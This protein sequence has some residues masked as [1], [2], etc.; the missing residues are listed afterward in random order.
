MTVVND[1]TALLSG[2]YWNGIEV[3][4]K[5]VIVTYSYPTS[6]PPYDPSTPGFTAATDA[7]F[8][9]FT[10]TEQRL[11]C[12]GLFTATEQTEA[13]QALGEWSAA[14]GLIFL[15]VAP[16]KGDINFA[17]IDFNTTNAPS[18]AG[19]GGIGFYP[20]GN[21][22]FFSDPSYFDDL[23]VSGDVFMN[24]QFLSNGAVNY[25]TLLHEIGHAVGL[26]H[27]TEVV[28][29]YAANPAVTHDQVLS[30][31]DPNRTV[32][33]TVGDGTTGANTHLLALDKAAAAAIYGPAGA[34]G[35][36]T[37]SASGTDAVSSWSFDAA[38]QT[39]T[40]TAT[41]SGGTIHGS[42]VNDVI[43][44]S[45]G[46]DH[47][48]GLAGDDTLIGG[49][50]N[51][52]LYG[53]SGTNTMTG[54]L[55]DDTY[56][57]SSATDTIV[58]K[59][60]EGFDSVYATVSFK[61]PDNCELL[62]INGAGLTA[63]GN[64]TGDRIF[65]DGTFASTLIGGAGDDYIVGGAG[66]DTIAGGG[67]VN[68]MYGNG[69]SDSFV[70][71]AVGDA[72][73]GTNLTTIGDFIDGT[74]TIDASAIRTVGGASP[75]QAL[76]FVGAAAFSHTA[77]EV[78][79]VGSG[80]DTIVEGD[81]N[82]DG[83]ADFRIQLTGE[84]TLATSNFAFAAP[85]CF[86]LGTAILTDRGDVAVE[87]LRPGDLVVTKSGALR[88]VL[89]VGQRLIDLVAHPEPATARPIRIEASA[90]GVGLPRRDL[91]LSPEHA[92]LFGDILVTAASLV[93]GRGIVQT[94]PGTV[95]YFHIALATHDVILAERLGCETLLDF[96]TQA[97]FDNAPPPYRGSLVP[98]LQRLTQGARVA[99]IRARI[100]ARGLSC[101]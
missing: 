42:S 13:T 29:D 47:L 28:V 1:Y 80:S 4:G 10:A 87:T 46:G 52:F 24:T 70:F 12:L 48:F 44:G 23:D 20:F 97:A 93:N 14:S 79:Q 53:G 15:Q 36:Y 100:D 96:D 67:G 54:G 90:I 81:V 51:D 16:G 21:H 6:L 19:A 9:P 71:K 94:Q 82:G 50:G 76:H 45:N 41:A 59:P 26:K 32:M 38:T 27:P 25:A 33:A 85:S 95:H 49:T 77:G 69:G 56:Y 31:D 89:W 43:H 68:T 91:Y 5:P 83:V 40:Q 35:V 86:C 57:V 60:N 65:G 55:G 74:D 8:Q 11:G 58:E 17:N 37:G 66:N 62:Q 72:A 98:C 88:P 78:H 75:G 64:D 92:V 2:K 39:L 61:L 18:Y 3:T 84:H 34:G 73:P 99:A 63:T 7:S 22:N 30:S 101:V